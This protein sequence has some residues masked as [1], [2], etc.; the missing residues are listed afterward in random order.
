MGWNQI[1]M[2]PVPRATARR[3]PFMLPKAVAV[4][5]GMFAMAAAAQAASVLTVD[6]VNG[7]DNGVSPFATVQAA[8]AASV[9]GDEI[10]VLPGVY[11]LAGTLEL[12]R[13]ITL[14]GPNAA[15]P[16]TGGGARGPEAVLSGSGADYLLR[17][18]ADQVTI[19]GFTLTGAV[20]AAI[21][22]S[23]E[24]A[25]QET[26]VR[27][28]IFDGNRNAFITTVGAPGD[29]NLIRDLE[30]SW[31]LVTNHSGRAFSHHDGVNGEDFVVEG[32]E[33]TT[34][35]AGIHLRNIDGARVEG[36]QVS[37]G[38]TL[39]PGVL[40]DGT[41]NSVLL[42]QNQFSQSGV[43]IVFW[44][45]VDL[46][47][48]VTIEEN[49]FANADGH[50]LR[51]RGSA[52][53]PPDL[54]KVVMGKNHFAGNG[55][56]GVR[57]DTPVKLDATGNY[58]GDPTGPAVLGDAVIGNVNFNPWYADAAMT[59]LRH[60]ILQ[61]VTIPHGE[62]V[63]HDNL[64]VV[65][66]TTVTV[67]GTLAAPGE[68]ILPP[69][70]V[71]EV[72]N[73]NLEL[74]GG[75]QL[76]GSFTFFNSLGSVWFNGDTTLTGGA[77]GLI[78][79]TDAH[80]ADGTTVTVD[81]NLVIDGSTVDSD[82]TFTLEVT[83]T[84]SFTMARTVFANGLLEIRSGDAAVY[85]NQ[86][87][88]STVAVT[89]SADGVRV[90]H[91]LVD[92]LA[93]WLTD[94]GVNTVTSVDGWG[95]V[96][97][98]AETQNRMPLGFDGTL[99]PPGRTL[100]PDGNVFI[101]PGD[102]LY[103][104][105]NVEALAQKI[106]AVEVLLGYAT[107]FFTFGNLALDP[108]W[109]V[110]IAA[111]QEAATAIGKLDAAV[112]LTF[113]HPGEEG[114]DADQLI[115]D[116][117]LE[118]GPDEGQT[119]VFHRVKLSDDTFG[120]ET[121]L[122]TGSPTFS[123]LTPFTVNTGF[124]TIDGTPPLIADVN[125]YS[126][127]TQ[128]GDDMTDPSAVVIQGTLVITAAAFDELAGIEDVSAVVTLEGP[129]LYSAS[130]T[131]TAAGPVI[132]GDGYT[133]YAFEY[134]V[135]AA[136]ENGIYDVVFTVTDR[137]GN[138]TSTSLGQILI[139]KFQVEAAVQLQGL[140]PG[141]ITREV[142]F[143]FTDMAETVLETRVKSV[144]FTSGVGTVLLTDVDTAGYRVSAKANWN[145][146]R[147]LDLGFDSEGQALVEFTGA[148]QLPGGDLNGSNVIGTADYGILLFY[149][150]QTGGAALQ[151]D[152]TGSGNVGTADFGIL[153]NNFNTVGDS[154]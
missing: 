18:R 117:K 130:Q 141:P 83:E 113:S 104:T 93:G 85:D 8:V 133:E 137:S 36:N 66:G 103:A 90:F 131:G 125:D 4:L 20:E 148:N 70:S 107:G 34:S 24:D 46:Q 81:G 39:Q 54:S 80:V 29:P 61:N 71:L 17:V 105:V 123:W 121:R 22:V 128:F 92:D 41:V 21:Q 154:P 89:A 47:G 132:N 84:G 139:N 14:R 97:T 140:V 1:E 76:S 10:D 110:L 63:E 51:V 101:Q 50:G 136:T 48:E 60:G 26:V 152:I 95:N 45:G 78:L 126:S 27:N 35:L 147:R 3:G 96:E 102:D 138:Q 75:S 62:T 7:L 108:A 32:N 86:F 118:A 94:G 106:T 11:S 119:R 122:T 44:D 25:V 87:E 31:N 33:I 73:G 124:I 69:G 53:A 143:V 144:E 30:F 146:R 19:E 114:T 56:A 65:P 129:A 57:N 91:N 67:A 74:G 153:R 49:Q 55:L 12:N 82:G 13:E 115:A 68:L 6:P 127:V 99:L 64:Y 142:T 116:V 135:A 77:D 16:P 5:I 88:N 9:D 40:L 120:G 151:A 79:I 52:A 15:A 111:D 37:L 134:E 145:L 59:K 112:G 2:P 149:F 23:G 98:F 100:D 150:N 109:N 28:N 42:T 58:W 38:N 72:V 43:G